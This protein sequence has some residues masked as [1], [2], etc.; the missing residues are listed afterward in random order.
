M[1]NHQHIWQAVDQV[2]ASNG[3]SVSALART[4]GL[5]PTTFNRSKRLVGSAGKKRW[6]STESIAKILNTTGLSMR[7]FGGIVDEASAVDSVEAQLAACDEAA[8]RYR[9][10]AARARSEARQA[11]DKEA[12]GALFEIAHQYERLAVL[13]RNGSLNRLQPA[14]P[15]D[16]AAADRK[17]AR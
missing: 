1:I 14:S 2:A 8:A 11:I 3:V 10:N 5:D 9:A 6:L 16:S 13:A 4:A 17:A 12:R 15:L 7:G